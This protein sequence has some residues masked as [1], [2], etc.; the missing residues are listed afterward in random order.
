[1]IEEFEDRFE[2]LMMEFT[3][4]SND[5][6]IG[7]SINDGEIIEDYYMERLASLT[8]SK[9]DLFWLATDLQILII[10]LKEF[11]NK[12]E[13]AQK[14]PQVKELWQTIETAMKLVK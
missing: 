9:S 2:E 8:K 3:R 12:F 4:T 6:G 11:Y 14:D 1:M 7:R 13:E 10:Q 5:L